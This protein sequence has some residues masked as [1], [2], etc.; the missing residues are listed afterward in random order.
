M[1]NIN[2][3]LKIKNNWSPA[4]TVK[5]IYHTKLKLKK[6]QMWCLNSLV[7]QKDQLKNGFECKVEKLSKVDVRPLLHSRS[8]NL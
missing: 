3:V 1:Y 2:F 7:T 5:V 8:F 4:A 6:M